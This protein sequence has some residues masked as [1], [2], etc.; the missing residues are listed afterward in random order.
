MTDE[1]L[2]FIQHAQRLQA[3]YQARRVRQR[4]DYEALVSSGAFRAPRSALGRS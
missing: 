4:A 1:R 2:A 3:D